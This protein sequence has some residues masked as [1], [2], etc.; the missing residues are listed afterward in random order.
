MD[1]GEYLRTNERE[2]AV[3]SLEWARSQ[4]ALVQCDEYAWKWVL[5]SLHN[6][7]QGFMVLGLWGG[8][9]LLALRDDIAAKWLRAYREGGK[10]PVEK[11]DDFLGLYRKVK[12]PTSFHSIGSVCFSGSETHD[13][14]LKRLN[15]IRNDFI[16]FT[17]KGWSLE[18]T[19]L[20]QICLDTL[21]LIRHLGWETNAVTWYESGHRTRA[22]R[23]ERL[24]RRELQ[25]LRSA[26]AA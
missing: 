22:R 18:K 14:S 16:H 12:S 15:D 6:A 1:S 7:A 13:R 9:G 2:E 10:F 25:R 20:P 11:L 24:L 4:A 26:Y 21:D 3:R 8:N 23:A 5:I 17:P 19:G